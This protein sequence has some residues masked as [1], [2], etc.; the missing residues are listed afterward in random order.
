MARES[1]SRKHSLLFFVRNARPLVRDAQFDSVAGRFNAWWFAWNVALDRPIVG[2]G[3][4]VFN[5]ELFQIYAPVPED[6]HVALKASLE[7]AG[8]LGITIDVFCL[9][10]C[11]HGPNMRF[12]DSVLCS[13]SGCVV[14]DNR[15]WRPLSAG[16]RPV[17]SALPSPS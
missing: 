15:P 9:S 8:V 10:Q 7:A 2:G 1:N 14:N 3:L 12:E 6:F 13:G 5:E 16:P 17:D 11:E 4:G